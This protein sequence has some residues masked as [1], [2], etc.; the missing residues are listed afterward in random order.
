[1]E[2][3]KEILAWRVFGVAVPMW[4]KEPILIS[5]QRSIL[6]WGPNLAAEDGTPSFEGR[7]GIYAYPLQA[8]LQEGGCTTLVPAKVALLGEVVIHEDYF[9]AEEVQIRELAIPLCHLGRVGEH[10]RQ[11][12]FLVS[13]PLGGYLFVC[14]ECAR[15]LGRRKFFSVEEVRE[16]WRRRYQCKVLPVPWWALRTEWQVGD[17]TLVFDPKISRNL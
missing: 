3:V 15:P 11:A 7:D 8:D 16:L 4:K 2:T 13:L 9:R 12:A 10:N 6:W 5:P 14:E 17:I 1:M